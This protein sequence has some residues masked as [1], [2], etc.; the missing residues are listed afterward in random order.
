MVA[1][2]SCR[3]VKEFQVMLLAGYVNTLFRTPAF[4]PLVRT[5]TQAQ[6]DCI[7]LRISKTLYL[8]LS[9]TIKPF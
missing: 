2:A 9:C 3:I 4:H 5:T 1:L 7:W 8:P 6:R